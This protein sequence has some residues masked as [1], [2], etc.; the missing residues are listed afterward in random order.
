MQTSRGKLKPR[1]G[2]TFKE[3]GFKIERV[4]TYRTKNVWWQRLWK[5]KYNVHLLAM[6][7]TAI[8]DICNP[9]T[10]ECDNLFHAPKQELNKEVI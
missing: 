5:P 7:K 9:H 3:L 6:T 1:P 10:K 4:D 8:Y 2:I